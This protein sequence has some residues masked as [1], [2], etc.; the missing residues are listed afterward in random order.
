MS[1]DNREKPR[2]AVL[3][4]GKLQFGDHDFECQIWNIS[5]GGAKV[6]V[7]LPFSEGTDVKLVLE[8]RGEFSAKVMWHGERN[9][10][11]KFDDPPAEIRKAFGDDA[12]VTLG[13][14]DDDKGVE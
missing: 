6:N 3:W 8:G 9:L 10:G 1:I 5:L 2:R 13:L 4:S 12:I 11:L 7:G 14:D